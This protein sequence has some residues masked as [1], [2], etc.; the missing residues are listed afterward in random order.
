MQ[1]SYILPDA[2]P[3]LGL[4]VSLVI[5]QCAFEKKA[6]N[7]LTLPENKL[8]VL[9]LESPLFPGEEQFIFWIQPGILLNRATL[10]T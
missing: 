5:K 9:S 3:F 7:G 8:Q 10:G 2:D 4:F 6:Q 1:P